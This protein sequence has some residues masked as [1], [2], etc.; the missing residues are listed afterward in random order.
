MASDEV[1]KP[2]STPPYPE[3][4]LS[5]IEALDEKGGSNKSSISKY[6]ESK[7]GELL[8]ESHA[9]LLAAHLQRMK[10]GGEVVM[11][12]NNYVKA[13]PTSPTP[14][15]RGRGRPPK[16]KPELPPGAA[17]PSP[18][19]RGRPPKPKD[20]LAAAAALTKKKE[21]A[22]AAAAGRGLGRPRGR[23]PK[24]A[25]TAGDDGESAAGAAASATATPQSGVK[26]GRGRPPKVKPPPFADVGFA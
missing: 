6:M 11:L 2:S 5:A 24:A 1:S 26:R 22:A 13:D 20:P 7:Y 19:P 25:R 23:P 18:R 21:A 3:M 16:P 10:D 8:P 4:I 9:S 14:V 15:K 17:L 12:K